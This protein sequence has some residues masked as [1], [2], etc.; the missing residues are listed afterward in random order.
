MVRI[1]LCEYISTKFIHRIDYTCAVC[2]SE[3]G[4]EPS[5]RLKFSNFI[6]HDKYH[7]NE[8][9][10]WKYCWASTFQQNSFTESIISV[11]FVDQNWICDIYCISLSFGSGIR[12]KNTI[13]LPIFFPST[14]FSKFY[15]SLRPCGLI[16]LEHWFSFHHMFVIFISLQTSSWMNHVLCG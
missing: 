4:L 13:G 8:H 2:G 1:L 10:W 5:I 12:L 16:S 11:Q 15:F 3:S 9:R 14:N 6:K 7:R